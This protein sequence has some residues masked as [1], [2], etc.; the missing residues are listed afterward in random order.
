MRA[1]KATVA[2]PGARI[3]RHFC[4]IQTW[5]RYGGCHVDLIKPFLRFLENSHLSG[6]Y[7][8]L[9]SERPSGSA[10]CQ[11]D[12]RNLGLAVNVDLL[13]SSDHNSVLITA[14]LVACVVPQWTV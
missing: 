1:D 13:A 12:Q 14:L 8:Q 4:D 7:A 5:E 2:V 9:R 11:S 3:I 6:T 10:A